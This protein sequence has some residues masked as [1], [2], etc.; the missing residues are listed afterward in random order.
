MIARFVPECD[1]S[2]P[3]R[4][5]CDDVSGPETEMRAMQRRFAE[6]SLAL[7]RRFVAGARQRRRREAAGR[8]V[9]QV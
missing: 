4:R 2:L 9:E 7:P 6:G 3:A 1:S 8:Q 5:V